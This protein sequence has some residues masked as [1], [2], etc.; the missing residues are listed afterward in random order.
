MYNPMSHKHC[1]PEFYEYDD[2]SGGVFYWW[3]NGV[4]C[5]EQNHEDHA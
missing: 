3:E 2:L 1:I 5:P 4:A